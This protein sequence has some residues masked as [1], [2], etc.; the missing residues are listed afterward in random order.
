MKRL[1]IGLLIVLGMAGY[2]QSDTIVYGSFLP[3]T[4]GTITGNL[5]V[6]GTI[7]GTESTFTNGYFYS[8]GLAHGMTALIPTDDYG[9]LYKVDGTSGGLDIWGLT[10]ANQA[11][12][13]RL[14]GIIGAA[15][16]TDSYAAFIM[17]GGKKNGTGWQAL[18]AAETVFTFLNYTTT[19]G[20]AY[21]NGEWI[22]TSLQNTPIGST[23]AS[24]GA[25][26]T[27]TAS[28]AIADNDSDTS[29]ATTA[30]AK[31]Q[32][33][34]LARSP[35][36]A[37]NMTAATSASTGI[38]VADS[39][40]NNMGT[41]N[42][43]PVI[44]VGIPDWKVATVLAQKH[45][46]GVVG[47]KLE[48]VVTTGYLKFTINGTSYTST[49]APTFVNGAMGKIATAIV[50]EAS[51]STAGSVTFYADGVLLGAA[52]AIAAGTPAT[53][54]NASSMY[55]LGTSAVRTAGNVSEVYIYN[56]ALS[57]AE[58]R[59]DY[60]NG[61]A[62]ADKWGSQV[63]KYTSNF[64]AG[65]DN[66]T[67]ARGTATGNIDIGGETDTLRYVCDNS[68]ANTHLSYRQGAYA[69]GS[70]KKHSYS[71]KYYIPSGQSNV[72]SISLGTGAGI[73]AGI[74][75]SGV[76]TALD[77]WTT[78]TGEGT[79]GASGEVYFIAVDGGAVTFQDAGGDDAFYVKDVVF[80]EIGATL[81]LEPEGI[82]T[83]IW[84]DS[85]SNNLDASY[86]T[87]GATLTRPVTKKVK[88]STPTAGGTGAVTVTIAMIL[89]GVLTANPS[90]DRAYTF[91]VG[92]TSDA[93]GRLNILDS[94]DWSIVNTNATY[95]VT[96]TS[97]D[98]THTIVGN[99]IVALSTSGLF[100]TV[101][102]A[103]STF[104]TYRL[105]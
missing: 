30:Y 20:T 50:R 97:P 37:V 23:I 87:A 69:L 6:T 80:T 72:D 31:S 36:Q 100:R 67:A 19:I 40:H 15:D 33:A 56:R 26:T 83:D 81:A 104:I 103:A 63:A 48:T 12:A 58:A 10:N 17:R 98:A 34:V 44:K 85:S 43:T 77:T 84:Y 42:F 2:A 88:Q 102:T 82:K 18:G 94:F 65:V 11:G 90:A 60:L 73:T 29:L 3:S 96:V 93:I 66:W 91:E 8:S 4:G 41:N 45:D 57:A 89:N 53:V 86:P 49:A 52:Q 21:G 99:P 5:S 78:V 105:N 25:F 59:L 35:N 16:P 71:F 92:G 24:T 7:S 38:T 70:F 55:I 47:W 95:K 9:A 14:T 61:V 62:F 32:D 28:T 27:A 64:T 54:T 39:S 79:T 76:L 1:L 22:L 46:G 13:L 51:P 74:T 68:A 75:W 101:K